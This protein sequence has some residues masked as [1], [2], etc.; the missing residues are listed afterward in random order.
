MFWMR[1]MLSNAFTEGTALVV[2]L[3]IVGSAALDLPRNELGRDR[4]I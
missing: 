4:V 3:A 2:A 1:S